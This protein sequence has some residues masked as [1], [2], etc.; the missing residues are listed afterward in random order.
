MRVLQQKQTKTR[1]NSKAC[2]AI[3][4]PLADKR[5]DGALIRL[6]GRYPDKGRCVNLKCKGMAYVIKGKGILEVEGKKITLKLGTLVLI[7]P[8]EKYFWQGNLE[9]FICCTPAWYKSQHKIV[10]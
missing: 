1:K 10:G 5:I 6:K 7:N 4:Y 2:T 3:E 8:K 9:I